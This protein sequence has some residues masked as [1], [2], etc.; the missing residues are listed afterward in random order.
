MSLNFNHLKLFE[1]PLLEEPVIITHPV[2]NILDFQLPLAKG[3][4]LDI[5]THSTR[6]WIYTSYLVAR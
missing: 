4:L 2:D 6:H 5:E 1:P 3:T